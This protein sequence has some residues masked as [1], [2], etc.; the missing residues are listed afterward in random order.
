MKPLKHAEYSYHLDHHCKIT[1]GVHTSQNSVVGIS[2]ANL[3]VN[4]KDVSI[5][6]SITGKVSSH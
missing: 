2:M 5:S 4:D 6:T 3:Q 1:T